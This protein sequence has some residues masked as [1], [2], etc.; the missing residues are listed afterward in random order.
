MTPLEIVGIVAIIL[1][2]AFAIAGLII[3]VPLFK[4]INRIRFLAGK[5][6]ES[7]IPAAEKLNDA[8]GDLKTEI[9]SISDLTR[10]VSSIVEQLEKVIRLARILITSPVIKIISASAGLI[11][12]L[13]KSKA[14]TEDK[15]KEEKE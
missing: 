12:G 15:D 1:I 6:N 10:S 4:L 13:S 11:S 2:S 5:L 14:S 9:S 8:V 3:A 7:I